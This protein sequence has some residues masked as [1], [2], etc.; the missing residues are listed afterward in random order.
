MGNISKKQMKLKMKTT[1]WLGQYSGCTQGHG[2]RLFNKIYTP[3]CRDSG[4]NINSGVRGLLMHPTPCFCS[5]QAVNFKNFLIGNRGVQGL[6]PLLRYARALKSLN[7]AGNGIRDWGVRHIIS[8]FQNDYTD[9]SSKNSDVCTLLV[10]DLSHNPITSAC[11]QELFNFYSS[12]KDVLMLGLKGTSLPNVRRQ[13][14][15][16]KAITKFSDAEP[17]F[18]LEAWRLSR[19]AD[20]FADRELFL[21]CEQIVELTHGTAIH[22]LTELQLKSGRSRYATLSF[23]NDD[24]ELESGEPL[25]PRFY[26]EPVYM[27]GEEHDRL[28]QSS[29]SDLPPG[30]APGSLSFRPAYGAVAEEEGAEGGPPDEE[31]AD[32]VPPPPPPVPPSPTPS[33]KSWASRR[34]RKRL[35]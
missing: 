13:Y 29:F 6:W 12:R 1:E 32:E 3:K 9:I 27:E 15:L 19:N 31:A 26:E 14:L 2:L 28:S 10:L 33:E 20:D 18:M 35:G 21:H 4:V 34:R 22:D 23:G 11:A 8:V 7:L 5:L 25:S 30:Q 17:Y 16:H 24:W